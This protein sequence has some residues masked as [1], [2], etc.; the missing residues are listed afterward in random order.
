MKPF[1]Q[2]ENFLFYGICV[3]DF[4]GTETFSTGNRKIVNEEKNSSVGKVG[5]ESRSEFDSFTFATTTQFYILQ[6]ESHKNLLQR[7][8]PSTKS[9][10]LFLM[11]T[12]SH[13]SWVF[14]SFCLRMRI[15]QNLKSS[16]SLRFQQSAYANVR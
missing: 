9:F 16:D 14:S 11:S 1:F 13:Y 6:S 3:H 7:F 5:G 15:K 12:I 2:P 10:F 4:V 8:S